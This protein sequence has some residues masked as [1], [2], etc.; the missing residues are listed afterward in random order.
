M[1]EFCDGATIAQLSMP[2]MRLPIALALGAPNRLPV[3][4]GA[5]DWATIG[6]LEFQVPDRS[7]FA[8]LGLAYAA[9]RA[10]GTAPAILSGANEVAVD[11]FLAGRIGWADIA[12]VVREVLDDGAGTAD[13]IADVL[14]ADRHARGRAAAVIASRSAA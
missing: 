6:N 12:L 8:C 13:E 14:E 3:P 7:T 5:I 4:Y 9:G 1:V 10:G 11:A 2:D